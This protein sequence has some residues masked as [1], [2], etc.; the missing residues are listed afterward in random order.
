MQKVNRKDIEVKA[1]RL[2]LPKTIHQE[3]KEIANDEDKSRTF[4][5]IEALQ[6]FITKKGKT[7]WIN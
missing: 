6:E 2:D 4:V 3:I 1:I 5:I 7:I